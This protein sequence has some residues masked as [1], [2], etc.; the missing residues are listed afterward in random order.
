VLGNE[1]LMF[2]IQPAWMRA[3]SRENNMK[4]WAQIGIYPF[5][6]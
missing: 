5:N 1:D 6:C 4:A 3:F 2:V